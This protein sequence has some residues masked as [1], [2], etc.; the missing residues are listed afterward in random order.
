[1]RFFVSA[2]LPLLAALLLLPSAALAQ[3]DLTVN[4]ERL[5]GEGFLF[6]DDD[7]GGNNRLV[8]DVDGPSVTA[9][10][11]VFGA[12]P[13]AEVTI[14]WQMGF[15]NSASASK[16]QAA[17]SQ[18]DQV[19]IGVDVDFD[20]G[21]DYFGQAAPLNCQASAKIRDNQ[22]D[23]PDDPDNSQASVSCDLGANLQHLDDDDNPKTPGDPSEA[24]LAAIEAA[25][26]P[27]KDVSV[28]VNNGKLTIKH[29]GTGVEL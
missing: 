8:F 13:G 28:Q 19:L 6:F 1:M 10:G 26:E 17:V 9:R 12:V 23:D 21:A 2:R 3:F 22:A 20:K 14:T 4:P 7:Q 11:Q 5:D 16:Q 15:P 18:S 29:K 27:R 25:F 24:V